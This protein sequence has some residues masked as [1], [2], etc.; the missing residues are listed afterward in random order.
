MIHNTK[1][2]KL[3]KETAKVRSGQVPYKDRRQSETYQSTHIRNVNL[4]KKIFN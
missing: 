4:W 1:I 3:T 2:T